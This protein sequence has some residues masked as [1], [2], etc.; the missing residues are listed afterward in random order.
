MTDLIKTT[1]NQNPAHVQ[2]NATIA[3]LRLT[4]AT[5]K[6]IG[7]QVGLDKSQVSRILSD[8][9][10][11][12]II[13]KS[14]RVYIAHSQGISKRFLQLCYDSDKKISL[15]AIKHYNQIIGLAGT[16]TVNQFFANIYQDNRSIITDDVAQLFG[17]LSSQVA[18]DED[19]VIDI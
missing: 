7:K 16:H 15:D 17:L 14:L 9:Q 2:R 10:C 13:D 18:G 5:V 11:K 1:P 6:D 3:Q 4:G 19:D 8:S 12:A